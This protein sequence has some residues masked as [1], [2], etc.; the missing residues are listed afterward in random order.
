MI[1]PDLELFP[2]PTRDCIW[3]CPFRE[4]CLMED[5]G[6]YQELESWLAA[7]F[8]PRPRK[9]DGNID[10]WRKNIPWPDVAQ[11]DPIGSLVE[12]MDLSAEQTLNILLPEK[13]LTEGK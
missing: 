13:Y 5:R 11:G 10:P 8:E 9:E 3:D 6:H 12:Q 4:A 2:N 1:D 7:E